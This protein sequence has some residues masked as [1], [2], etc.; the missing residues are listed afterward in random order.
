MGC[1]APSFVVN[2]VTASAFELLAE[3]IISQE[4]LRHVG[5]AT[6]FPTSLKDFQDISI[7]FGNSA[8]FI[9]FLKANNKLS[10]SQLLALSASGLVSVP[11]L[12]THDL[13][14]RAEFYEIKPNSRDGVPAGRAKIAGLAALFSFL[15]LPYRAGTIWRPDTRIKLWSGYI[16]GAWIEAY[17]HYFRSTTTDGLIL[18]EICIEGEI[19]KALEHLALAVLVATVIV[20]VLGLVPLP[21]PVP[22]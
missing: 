5:R 21:I 19:Q 22:A 17:L 15:G 9:G 4:Y 16:T 7:G 6:F 18:Y 13:P 14:R 8:L 11:D 1:I 20:I 12:M 3:S 2:P 10:V